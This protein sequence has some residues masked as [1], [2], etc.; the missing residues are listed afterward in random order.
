M[1]NNYMLSHV[2]GERGV[3][4]R[5]LQSKHGVKVTISDDSVC[6]TGQMNNVKNAEKDIFAILQ[7]QSFEAE[8]SDHLVGQIVGLKGSTINQI[9]DTS[10][11]HV[12]ISE[13]VKDS[14]P[15]FRSLQISGRKEKIEAA[16]GK[17]MNALES[18]VRRILKKKA[19]TDS[20]TL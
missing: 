1:T 13:R 10:G 20:R 17:V 3:G 16:K 11:A 6:I 9:R 19:S 8:I 4:Q 2:V 14:E 15:G 18:V 7:N 5:S 12:N